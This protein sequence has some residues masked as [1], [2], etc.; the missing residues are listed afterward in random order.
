MKNSL[1]FMLVFLFGI[2]KT[3]FC[4]QDTV[5]QKSTNPQ[6]FYFAEGTYQY[7][8]V[9]A[10]N[11]FV[12]GSNTEKES[13]RNFQSFSLKFGKQTIGEK[14]WQRIYNY[15]SYGLGLYVADFFN[16]EELGTPLGIYGFF[17]APFFR[18][19][20]F[21]LGYEIKFGATFNWRKYDPV[22]NGYNTAI[23]AGECFMVD[24]GMYANYRI[25]PHLSA[26]VNADLT[27]FSN[28]G[29][30]KPNLGLNTI[31]PSVSLKYMLLE[32]S[33]FI[34]KEVEPFRKKNEWLVSVFG[35]SKNVI[36]DSANVD[37]IERFE[38]LNYP[39]FGIAATYNWVVSRKSKIG[40]GISASYNGT[41]DAQAAVN[42][43]DLEPVSGNFSNKIQLSIFPSYELVVNRFSFLLQPAIYLYRKK[44]PNQTPV[45]YQ[46][47]GLKYQLNDHLFV[48][49][50]L[51]DY[52]FHISD[53][54]EW[55]VG[56]RIMWSN[57]QR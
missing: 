25:S 22:T 40:F 54:V 39:V 20:K 50:T 10:T 7:G 2:S 38:G 23:S 18:R 34:H 31:A 24:A 44:I 45:F 15:P 12:R 6:N 41:L 17:Q 9:F 3:A 47:I 42:S 8:H 26:S 4:Q 28:G 56:Y 46:K 57:S 37:V 53:F 14:E 49:I 52:S 11:D 13:I 21:S 29:L 43:N 33:E 5:N 27:H 19:E 55:T 51:R 32:P 30:K 1:L 36:F 35:G 16:P 48:G